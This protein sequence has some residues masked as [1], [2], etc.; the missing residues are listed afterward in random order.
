VPIA[1]SITDVEQ[2]A[3]RPLPKAYGA[4]LPILHD[5]VIGRQVLLYSLDDVIEMNETFQTKVYC[6]GHIAIGDDSGGRA[7]VISL[8][9][10]ECNLFLVDQGFMDPDYFEPLNTTLDPWLEAKCPIP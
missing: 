2:W 10:P 1:T 4:L 9:D 5:E 6:P 8:D 3:G 7:I